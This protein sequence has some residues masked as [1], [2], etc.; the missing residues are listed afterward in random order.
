MLRIQIDSCET[1]CCPVCATL[2]CNCHTAARWIGGLNST[3]HTIV[4]QRKRVWPPRLEGNDM[5]FQGRPSPDSHDATFPSPFPLLLFPLYAYPPLTGSR[6]FHSRKNLE[7]KLI[8][9]KFKRTLSSQLSNYSPRI[10]V[11][12]FASPGVPSDCVGL[13]SIGWVW[14]LFKN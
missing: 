11:T 3:V 10:S 7:S 14:P 9:G 8:V 6:G 4:N 5:R 2:G 12:H 13:D 1:C